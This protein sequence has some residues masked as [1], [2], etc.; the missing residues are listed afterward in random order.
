MNPRAGLCSA[1]I[2]ARGCSRPPNP[3]RVR[4][5][6]RPG[7]PAD[8]DGSAATRGRCRVPGLLAAQRGFTLIELMVVFVLI[9][10]L[11]AMILPDMRST[12]EDALLRSTGR[13]LVELCE[14]AHSR[15][16]TLNQLHRIRLDLTK[17]RGFVE[18][19]A[20]D[21]GARFVPVED[22]PGGD[23]ALDRRISVA[24]RKGIAAPDAS[25]SE[26]PDGEAPAGEMALSSAEFGPGPEEPNTV[27]FYPD[28]TADAAELLLRDREGFQLALRIN[29]VTARVQIIELGRE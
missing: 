5:A 11:T 23:A 28:G 19:A 27:V 29:P 14:F 16:I 1:S 13:T 9:G 26:T 6:G 2:L 21:S 10:I 20:P 17:A 25:A 18:S 8:G 4:A 3:Q 22:M 12:Y 15:A 7:H 24:V